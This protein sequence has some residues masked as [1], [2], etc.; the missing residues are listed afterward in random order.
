MIEP[1]RT[2]GRREG[3]WFVVIGALLLVIA[4]VANPWSLARW[5]S[6]DG[7]ISRTSK[8]LIVVFELA[9]GY[10]GGWLIVRRR[11]PVLGR[12]T[13]A[14]AYG[15]IAILFLNTVLLFAVAN[16]VVAWLRPG[17][18]EMQAGY[19][20]VQEL[21]K[22]DPGLFHRI[23][24]GLSDREIEAREH[25]P[26]I[27]AHPTLEF[28]ELPIVSDVYNVG[29]ENMR[30][31]RFVSAANAESKINGST[32]VFGGSTTFGHG[33]ADNETI[34]A[35]LNILD[36]PTVYINFGTQ[37]YDQSLEIDKLLLLLKKG[38]H[39]SRAIFVDGLNDIA[40]MNMMN[41][42]P[43]E[44]PVRLYD[45]YRYRS[46]IESVMEPDREF[47][48]RKMPLFDLLFTLVDAAEARRIGPSDPWHEENL[49]D[50]TD[51]Y[52][53]N[54]VLHYEMVSRAGE[55]YNAAVRN[56]A[57]YKSKILRYYEANDVFLTHLA[58]A[59][60]FTYTVYFQPL[61]DLSPKNP[62]HRDPVNFRKE[63]V[64]IYALELQ[65]TVRAAINAGTLLHYC[66]ISDAD[67]ACPDCYVDF[68]HYGPALCR[69]IARVIAQNERI[70]RSG[71]R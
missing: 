52:H 18:K 4:L 1:S 31:T 43:E 63:P 3:R 60:G 47:V 70:V 39:P 50:P 22:K 30:Y 37:A 6:P 69:E 42:K 46:N 34:P 65:D 54:P 33:V 27:T 2:P 26:N 20:P 48:L 66:D 58:S 68:T 41:F 16:L 61:G 9:C 25:P 17:K 53:T 14:R 11:W 49:D 35:F 24:P 32:W 57:A 55:D 38:Y 13:I 29:L 71:K 10:S 40:Q 21:L 5:F 28:M 12:S 36:S 51:L 67:R 56:L 59:Y 62:F 15:N 44:S 64:Y 8:L 19:I 7:I 23:Y 45:A